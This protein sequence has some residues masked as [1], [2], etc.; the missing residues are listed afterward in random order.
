MAKLKKLAMKITKEMKIDEVIQ[1]YPETMEVFL[2]SGFHCF[3]CAGA[4]FENLEQG[5]MVHGIDIDKLI[6][7]LNNVI[8]E[9]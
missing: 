4:A 8:H 1:K 5:A 9:K 6:E 7:K 2:E 3:G